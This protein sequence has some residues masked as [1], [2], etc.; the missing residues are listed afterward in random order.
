MSGNALPLNGMR[1]YSVF[2]QGDVE[3]VE[4]KLKADSPVAGKQVPQLR[5]PEECVLI[6]VMHDGRMYLGILIEALFALLLMGKGF[7]VCALHSLL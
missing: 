2:Q 6:T 1:I 5:L 3:I 7:M 4:A